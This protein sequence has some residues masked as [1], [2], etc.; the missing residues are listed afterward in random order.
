VSCPSASFCAAV[1]GHGNAL[2]YNGSSWSSPSDIGGPTSGGTPISI[3]G[4]NLTGATGVVVA[5]LA[6]TDVMVVS[7]TTLTAT[8]PAYPSA[9]LHYV[10]VTTPS[11]ESAKTT[12]AEF[13][14]EAPPTVTSIS[15]T[16]GPSSGGTDV[17][18][19]GTNLTGATQVLF[20][21]VAATSFTVVSSTEVT[22]VS[23]AQVSGALNVYVTTPGGTSAAAAG[24]VFTYTEPPPTVTAVSPNAG[25][26]SGNTAI[27]ITGTNFTEATGVSVAGVAA[28][29]VSVVNS[30]TITATTPAYPSAGL[31]YVLVSTPYGTSIKTTGAEFTYEIAPTVTAVSPDFGPTTG[32]T[33]MTITGINF[34]GATSVLVAGLAPTDVSV[35]NS[36]TI[37][38]TTPAYPSAGLHYVVV[39]TPNGTSAKT[40][41]AEFT[42][43]APPTV[44]AVSPDF[45][46]TTGGTAI[47]ITGTNF[48]AV[49]SVL[50]AG[51][52]PTD[53]SVVNS[54]TI[55]ATT[56]AYPSG[57]LHYVVVS[58]PYGTST[59]TTGAEFTYEGA[60][61]V[62][63]VSPHTGRTSGGTTITITGTSLAGDTLVSV[64]GVAATDVTVVSPTTVTA[65]TPPYSA[66]LHYVRVST[67]YG[68]STKTTGAEFTYIS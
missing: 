31:H 24:D 10:R 30:T 37:T 11:G 56:P 41:G 50:V 19:T 49:T 6:A 22:A 20:G 29:D 8:T 25:P 14:Y 21:A 65:K 17:A 64:A 15:P 13:T 39:T 40:T 28:T 44:T 47:T 26:A 33:A 12:G 68:S 55:T 53:V 36:T 62:T 1:D 43:E 9:G 63:S 5:G 52:A 23:P 2:T 54:T 66:G 46:P 60:P 67:L 3:T 4:T 51:R 38:A 61:T 48:T 45:G 58:T 18:I 16:S 57:S 59:K 7:P 27:T 35:V 42:Y 34:T 32:G